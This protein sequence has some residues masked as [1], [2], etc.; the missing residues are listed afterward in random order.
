MDISAVIPL[1]KVTEKGLDCTVWPY[2]PNW[3]NPVSYSYEWKTTVF[4]SMIGFE[5]RRGQR[6][7][8]RLSIEYDYL[9]YKGAV[10]IH[11]LMLMGRQH[12]HFLVPN[13]LH[14]VKLTT[15]VVVG[16][17][18]LPTNSNNA[19]FTA[20]ELCI[21]YFS[22]KAYEVIRI[23]SVANNVINLSTPT[24]YAWSTEIK[25]YPLMVAHMGTNLA[26][27]SHT[28]DV[29]TARCSFLVTPAVSTVPAYPSTPATTYLKSEVVFEPYDWSDD[30]RLEF[31]QNFDTLDST[32]GTVHYLKGEMSKVKRNLIFLVHTAARMQWF[33][34]F[35]YRRRGQ[36]VGFWIESWEA[37]MTVLPPA[38]FPAVPQPLRTLYLKGREYADFFADNPNKFIIIKTQPTAVVGLGADPV[39]ATEDGSV[40]STE[41]ADQIRLPEDG[42]ATGGGAGSGT[43]ETLHPPIYYRRVVSATVLNNASKLV[44]DTDFSAVLS[45]EAVARINALFHLRLA[46]DKVEINMLTNS[47]SSVTLPVIH[48]PIG[49]GLDYFVT[50]FAFELDF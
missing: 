8:P 35:I 38:D 15:P 30:P 32:S 1:Y 12:K 9:L 31:M 21:V 42:M 17:L 29:S 4:T 44:V 10:A 3:A 6:T 36:Q 5:Q 2:K 19:Q 14:G 24:V 41:T 45:A 28:R 37:P 16:A 22:E 20:G 43:L 13:W 50:N 48:A 49:K 47:V 34:E 27:T 11:S 18:A 25:I 7:K 46:T 39:R 26:M 23:A 33:R 40:R